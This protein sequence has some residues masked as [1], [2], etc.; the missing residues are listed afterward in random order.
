MTNGNVLYG[1]AML[2]AVAKEVPTFGR[3]MVVKSASDSTL[4]QWPEIDQVFK[5]DDNGWTRTFTS[6]EDAYTA[7]QSNNNDVI[8]LTA[9]SAHT[10]AAGLAMTKNRV[11]IMGLDGNADRI[12]Q[13]GCKVQLT[14]TTATAYVLKDTGV[15]NTFRNIKWIQGS[16]AA[17]ALT[18]AQFGGEGTFV[19]NC[20]F[21]FGVADNLGSTSA[22][23][24]L[25][26]SDS[27]TFKNCSFGTDVLST[28]AARSV[29]NLTPSISGATSADG[30]KSNRFENCEFKV[31][32]TQTTTTLISTLTSGFK[33]INVW[34]DCDF[35]SVVI[36]SAS[37]VK[38]AVA[39]KTA[40]SSTE[41]YLL[42]MNPACSCTAFC[43][44]AVGN[45]GVLM[46]NSAQVATAPVMMQPTA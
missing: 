13:Q 9:N 1:R 10:L 21:I 8:V 4:Y 46:K 16:T 17:T 40:A 3:I 22:F 27:A 35:L 28:T 23:E 38:T 2:D 25:L 44:A 33:F 43:T 14:G 7:A 26:G 31:Q 45:S 19:K 39:V 42:F 11:H 34:K 6:L 29:M 18:V 12:D 20:S 30:A 24:V 41:G 36:T 5:S 15:R 37:A 32:T